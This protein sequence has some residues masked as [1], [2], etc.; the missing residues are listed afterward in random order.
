MAAYKSQQVTNKMPVPSHGDASYLNVQRFV[1]TTTAALT[2]ADTIQFGDLP[3]YARVI[4]AYLE[5]TDLDTNGSP[6]IALNV[7]DAA[8]VDRYFAAANTG[9]AGGVTRMTVATGFGYRYGKAGGRITGAPSTNAATGVA[10][11]IALT[12]LYVVEDPGDGYPA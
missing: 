1:V 8:D 9:Q 10:G 4:D 5:A 3:A 7:G 6:T 12:I 11:E 2:T